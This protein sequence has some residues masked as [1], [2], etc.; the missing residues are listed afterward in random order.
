MPNIDILLIPGLIV[1]ILIFVLVY[2][3]YNIQIWTKL[4]ITELSKKYL[5]YKLKVQLY[6]KYKKLSSFKKKKII[7]TLLIPYHILHRKIK[8]N[9]DIYKLKYPI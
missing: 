2:V 1:F 7:Y 8:R 3:I 4:L 6:I 9:I 5:I